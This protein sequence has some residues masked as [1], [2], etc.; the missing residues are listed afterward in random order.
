MIKL[1]CFLYIITMLL[2]VF[3]W[4]GAAADGPKKECV[5]WKTINPTPTPIPMSSIYSEWIPM[6]GT[7]PNTGHGWVRA[8]ELASAQKEWP[9]SDILTAHILTDA[10]Y[11]KIAEEYGLPLT[12]GGKWTYGFQPVQGF[13]LIYGG[14]TFKNEW[15]PE[16]LRK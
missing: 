5:E 4:L 9:P 8:T 10:E 2:L 13:P 3:V 11:N 7:A 14:V 12:Q 16:R 1:L 6:P 15:L